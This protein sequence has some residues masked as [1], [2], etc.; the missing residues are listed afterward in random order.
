MIVI[1]SIILLLPNNHAFTIDLNTLSDTKLVKLLRNVTRVIS[2]RF[3]QAEPKA[4]SKTHRHHTQQDESLTSRLDRALSSSKENDNEDNDSLPY[5]Y[6]TKEQLD[7]EL[8]DIVAQRKRENDMCH[9]F[10]KM[11]L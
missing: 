9:Q 2:S 6:V 8:D 4:P 11:K 10:D 1:D 7:R 5:P 3:G